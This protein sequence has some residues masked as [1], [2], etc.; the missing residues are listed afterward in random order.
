M[1]PGNAGDLFAAGP[2]VQLEGGGEKGG[3]RGLPVA[4]VGL[5][6]EDH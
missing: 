4:A 2:S 1:I 6:H 3:E 5:R